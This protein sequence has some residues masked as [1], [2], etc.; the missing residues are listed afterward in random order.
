MCIYLLIV[1]V[2]NKDHSRVR[3]DCVLERVSSK[4]SF[5]KN[6]SQEPQ[7]IFIFSHS[8]KFLDHDK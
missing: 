4:R 3:S 6:S 7:I 1:E 8:K 2:Y 5:K